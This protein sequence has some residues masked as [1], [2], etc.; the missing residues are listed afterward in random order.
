M[1]T[2][3]ALHEVK[4][5]RSDFAVLVGLEDQVLPAM[6]GGGDG[7]ITGLSNVAPELFVNL[8]KSATEGDLQTA[9]ELHRR[10][11]SLMALGEHSDP[12]V[13]AVKL[14]MKKRGVPI[15]PTVRGPTLP[16]PPEAEERIDAVLH[17]AGLLPAQR[18]A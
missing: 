17:A 16:A 14:A 1:H 13:G 4:P 7:A 11:L 12:I 9:A 2:V 18:E 15:S 6:L 8:V 5:V 3:N 10:V